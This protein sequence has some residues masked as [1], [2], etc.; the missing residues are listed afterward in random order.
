M[1]CPAC[2]SVLVRGVPGSNPPQAFWLRSLC[3]QGA[4]QPPRGLPRFQRRK[5]PIQFAWRTRHEADFSRFGL[6]RLGSCRCRLCRHAGYVEFWAARP[7][8]AQSGARSAGTSAVP[9]R[10]HLPQRRGDDAQIRR[11]VGGSKHPG[12]GQP[13]GATRS[14]FVPQQ[15]PFAQ[16][17]EYHPAPRIVLP[18]RRL[19]GPPPWRAQG[20]AVICQAAGKFAI[21]T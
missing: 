14:K 19:R 11:F 21:T 8:P 1:A 20:R 12:R 5:P 6:V 2:P 18:C 4:P 13:C 15:W 10:G 17:A 3:L 7:Q 16:A 9:A